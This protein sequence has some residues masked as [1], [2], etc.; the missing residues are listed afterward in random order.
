MKGKQ[1]IICDNCGR[2]GDYQESVKSRP[3]EGLPEITEIGLECPHCRTWAHSQFDGP[4]LD[5]F[6][7]VLKEATDHLESLRGSFNSKAVEKALKDYH[8]AKRR[9]ATE[10]KRFNEVYRKKLDVIAPSEAKTR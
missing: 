9:M 4:Q 8:R 1:H 7:K 10:H 6:R 2:L 5:G 3:V